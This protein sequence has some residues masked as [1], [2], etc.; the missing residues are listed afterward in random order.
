MLPPMPT[1]LTRE[2][3]NSYESNGYLHAPA[4]IPTDLLR[5]MRTVLSRWADDT[6]ERWLTDGLI[7]DPALISTFRIGWR[8]FG[9]T[10]GGPTTSAAPAATS[11][12]AKCSTS[13]STLL[14]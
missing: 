11:S 10:Q 1:V 13:W 8:G 9:R 6:I 7:D 5:L 4:V 2:Q 12:V 14:C 3:C